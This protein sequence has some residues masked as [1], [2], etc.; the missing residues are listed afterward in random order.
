MINR[1]SS[2]RQMLGHSFLNSRL[3]GALS[4]D[5]IAGYFRSSMLEVAGEALETMAGPVRVMCNSDLNLRDVET[6]RAAQYAMRQEWC[7]AGPEKIG[8]VAQP[9]FARL[10]DF[11]IAG[12]LQVRVLPREK[13]GLIHGKA[14]VIALAGGGKTSFVGSANETGEAWQTNY[15]LIWEDDSPEAVQWVQEEFDALWNSPFAVPL[16]E[17]VVEDIGRLARRT[18]ISSVAQW[19]QEAEPEAPVIEAPVYLKEY[20]LWE[21]QK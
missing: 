9:R 17:F 1:F 4:Y 14:G 3:T 18:V 11:L 13:F 8:P 21:H 10:Y 20:G 16:A 19:R 6:A 5:R 2:R 12:K 7:A 15:E